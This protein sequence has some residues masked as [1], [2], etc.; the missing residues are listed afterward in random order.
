MQY[1]VAYVQQRLVFTKHYLD[2]TSLCACAVW[3]PYPTHDISV[4]ESELHA[5]LK[6]FGI[7]PFKN[8]LNNHPSVYMNWGGLHSKHNETISI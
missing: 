4:L 6:A 3:A 8:G 1:M 5:G 2:L 7:H